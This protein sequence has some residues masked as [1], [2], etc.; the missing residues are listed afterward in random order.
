METLALA[1]MLV[2]LVVGALAA[3][4]AHRD[5]DRAV[6]AA[7]AAE[8]A[9]PEPVALVGDPAGVALPAPVLTG[10][11][12]A[13]AR[14]L[15]ARGIAEQP[16]GSNWSPAIAV[17]TDGHREPW[18]ADF[19]SWVLRAGGRPL[20]GGASG[21]WRIAGA[22]AVR[23]WFLA[24]GRWASRAGATP[25]PGDVVYFT[26]SHVGIV[27]SVTAD[28]LV[29]IEGNASDALRRRVYDG[30]RANREIDG[31]GRP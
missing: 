5:D 24:R 4:R 6:H 14:S 17:F 30:W 19:V 1:A 22:A 10:G 8:N 9:A 31:F 27:E 18:C 16:A 26:W 11:P 7:L 20:T 21:G 25:A 23:A 2:L 12:L 13:V 15:L 29:T 3:A 28:R